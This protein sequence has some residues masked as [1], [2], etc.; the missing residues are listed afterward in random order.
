MISATYSVDDQ[1]FREFSACLAQWHPAFVRTRR[2]QAINRSLMVT[3]LAAISSS[4]ATGLGI[5]AALLGSA[6]IMVAWRNFPRAAANEQVRLRAETRGQK[7]FEQQ[8]L[9]VTEE[10]INVRG[11]NSDSQ[12]GWEAV[13]FW[14]ETASCIYFCLTPSQAVIVPKAAF[15]A[16]NAD[17]IRSLATSRLG[18]PKKVN[19]GA[20]I[21]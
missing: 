11:A 14:G 2:I 3:A 7:R 15:S 6:W 13:E 20:T 10:A 19:V 9:T 5:G 1:A 16:S 17:A 18:P 4:V 21:S 12:I 8:N